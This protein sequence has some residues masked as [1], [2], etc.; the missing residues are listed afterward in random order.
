MLKINQLLGFNAKSKVPYLVGSSFLQN[1]TSRTG[2]SPN[3]PTETLDG[4]L[5][6]AIA[7][8]QIGTS[9]AGANWVIPSGWTQILNDY[10][11][12]IFYKIANQEGATVT[13]TCG[14]ASTSHAFVLAYRDASY[15][16]V[17]NNLASVGMVA[18]FN[19]TPTIPKSVIIGLA[20]NAATA[21]ITIAPVG[22]SPITPTIIQQDADSRAPSGTVVG[23]STTNLTSYQW[24][25]TGSPSATLRYCAVVL[26]PR[27]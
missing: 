3:I 17:Y 10:N 13:L 26:K 1:S 16:T 9:V 5:L 23:I 25:M 18:S 22:G 19:I 12:G 27:E 20:R 21:S 4:D 8:E 6:I 15:D 11:V 14:T 24:S 2:I 7:G